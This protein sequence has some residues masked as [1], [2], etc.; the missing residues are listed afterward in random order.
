MWIQSALLYVCECS[1]TFSKIYLNCYFNLP[2]CWVPPF[3]S[4]FLSKFSGARV[5]LTC[6]GVEAEEEGESPGF[7]DVI[8]QSTLQSLRCVT[9]GQ[10]STAICGGWPPGRVPVLGWFL[11]DWSLQW[12]LPCSTTIFSSKT[13]RAFPYLLL[14]HL[15]PEIEAW[16][17]PASQVM[18]RAGPGQ[19]QGGFGA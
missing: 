8:G 14:T 7:P 18:V 12:I 5:L 3:S 17:S 1:N 4:R 15:F 10:R 13:R 6:L 2:P 16:R 11:P 9:R 19:E